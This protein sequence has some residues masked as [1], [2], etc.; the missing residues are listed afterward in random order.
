LLQLFIAMM[1]SL[2]PIWIDHFAL[3]Y[4]VPSKELREVEAVTIDA[5]ADYDH[6]VSMLTYES[7]GGGRCALLA[8]PRSTSV[9][10]SQLN[11]LTVPL[12]K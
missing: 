9:V 6:A 1:L 2:S 12:Q 8:F 4:T 11:R 3:S 5:C 10:P 7:R